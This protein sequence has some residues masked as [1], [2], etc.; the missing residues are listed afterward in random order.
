MNI[1]PARS[2]SLTVAIFILACLLFVVGYASRRAELSRLQTNALEW[3]QRMAAATAR[4]AT[5][6]EQLNHVQ[7]DAYVYEVARNRLGMV[8]PG[9]E[10]II[11]VV[12]PPSTLALPQP[13][14]LAGHF[15]A[16]PVW[17]RWF[18]L[19]QPPSAAESTPH[20]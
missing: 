17:R 2:Y 16:L 12:L 10:L 14:P 4:Q 11:P 9:D 18:E 1:Q 20:R 8:Q 19:F 7:R 15:V 5:L 6:R 3:Q 13:E